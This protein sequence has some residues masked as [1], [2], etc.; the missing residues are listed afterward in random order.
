[1]KE[2]RGKLYSNFP[3]FILSINFRSFSLMDFRSLGY[4]NLFHP[5]IDC[6]K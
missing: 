6:L 3:L 2:E 4:N 1:M 5:C